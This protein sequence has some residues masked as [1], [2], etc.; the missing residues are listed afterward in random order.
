MKM[1][2]RDGYFIENGLQADFRF[3]RKH[4]VEDRSLVETAAGEIW[5]ETSILRYD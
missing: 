5:V 2:K 4:E 1:R 3:I